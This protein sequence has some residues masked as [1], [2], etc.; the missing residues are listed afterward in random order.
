[1]T[2][3]DSGSKRTFDSGYQRDSNEG[4]ARYDLIPIEALERIANIYPGGAKKY[5]ENNWRLGANYSVF[6]ESALRHL[7]RFGKGDIDED[8]LAQCVWNCLAILYFQ[9]KQRDDLNDMEKYQ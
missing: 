1:M 7:L 4:K 6:Y 3:K 8:H 2:I 5:G 9:E